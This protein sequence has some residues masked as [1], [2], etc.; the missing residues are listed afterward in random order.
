MCFSWIN[1]VFSRFRVTF[2]A[3]SAYFVS[4][5]SDLH[6][7]YCASSTAVIY[8]SCTV[9][10]SGPS[11]HMLTQLCE[12]LAHHRP[13]SYLCVM[14]TLVVWFCSIRRLCR[15]MADE[16]LS[17]VKLFVF[18]QMATNRICAAS[19]HTMIRVSVAVCFWSAPK[20]LR[21]LDVLMFWN[22]NS[23]PTGISR[24]PPLTTTHTHTHKY[25][26]FFWS[27]HGGVH[28]NIGF[29]IEVIVLVHLN[30]S[31]YSVVIITSVIN[32]NWIYKIKNPITYKLGK[33]IIYGRVGPTCTQQLYV[34]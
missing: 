8:S 10:R 24:A 21:F 12:M 5:T 19:L 33:L 27:S 17:L 11:C 23:P 7:L 20:L 15:V 16:L 30:T 18:P 4:H 22:K 28:F 31:Q 2:W 14:C 26:Q 32:Y 6:G 34:I 9:S 1:T 3:F 13:H 29:G 25:T